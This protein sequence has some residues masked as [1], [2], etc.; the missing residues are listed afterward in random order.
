MA[1]RHGIYVEEVPF[2]PLTEATTDVT[3][4]FVVGTA[5]VNLTQLSGY[6]VNV[7]ILAR[8]YEEAV[9]ALGYSDDWANFTL[10]EVIYA[11]FQLYRQSPIVLVNVLDPARHKTA[12][13][14]T[15]LLL[16]KG[17]G[18]INADGVLTSTLV[19]TSSDGSKTYVL[20]TDYRLTTN[21]AGRVVIS[22]ISTGTIGAS[23]TVRVAYDKLD[24]SAVTSADIIGGTDAA[25]GKVS[26]LELLKQVYP[27]FQVVPSLV[28]APGFSDDPVVAA[29]LNA[30][31]EKISGNFKAIALTDLPADE[32]YL[33]LSGWKE[34]NNYDFQSEINSWPLV[35][36]QGKTYRYSTHLAALICRTDADSSGVPYRSPSSK[37][38]LVDG[39]VM[40]D[41]TEVALTIDE[42]NVLNGDGIVTALNFGGWKAWGNRTAIYPE[43]TDPQS[44]FIP[45]RR[46]FNWVN[47]AL[48][49]RFANDVDEPTDRRLID[50]VI[51]EANVWLNG[52]TSSGYILGGRVEF[53]AS[54]NPDV[55]LVNG[56]M[57]F[58]L[59]LTPPSPAQEISYLVAYDP[60]YLAVLTA[61]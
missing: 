31:A 15:S 48:I 44:S 41:G 40:A 34:D 56:K 39:T 36:Y 49:L 22:R 46:M 33:D 59:Y 17:V 8:T 13:T 55:N 1:E 23:D 12:V 54:D 26:G 6:P 37:E 53:L 16:V 30:K 18:T 32:K 42:A 21:A 43:K 20:G 52:L 11:H 10:S 57:L 47:N 5:P 3:I 27:R 9:S 7:P 60:Q 58:R 25:T 45:V 29:V 28:L 38:L 4:P 2:Q 14:A 50:S 35:T 51:D 19:V 61:A 24:G